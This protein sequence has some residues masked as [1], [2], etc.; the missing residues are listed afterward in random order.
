MTKAQAALKEFKNST[1]TDLT[2]FLAEQGVYSTDSFDD[3]SSVWSF[4]DGSTI[5]YST[6]GGLRK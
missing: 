5:E 1:E 2:F 4:D 3:L 6:E